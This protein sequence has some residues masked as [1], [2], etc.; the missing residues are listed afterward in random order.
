MKP[1]VLNYEI[2]NFSTNIA[3]LHCTPETNT[4]YQLSLHKKYFLKKWEK[5]RSRGMDLEGVRRTSSTEEKRGRWC[6][7]LNKKK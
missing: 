3:S 2:N 6:I 5:I 4:I 1:K 7:F